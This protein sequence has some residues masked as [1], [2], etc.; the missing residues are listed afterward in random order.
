[1]YK[2]QGLKDFSVLIFPTAL[3]LDK[4]QWR[5]SD[6]II[7]YYHNGSDNGLSTALQLNLHKRTDLHQADLYLQ[8]FYNEM[9]LGINGFIAQGTQ[10]SISDNYIF[11]GYTESRI[12]QP[13]TSDTKYKKTQIYYDRWHNPQ[14][15]KD[16]FIQSIT[17]EE[18]TK[19]IEVR[20]NIKKEE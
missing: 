7:V 4:E 10:V 14:L 18:V 1:M 13:I 19:P 5:V 2:R 9:K 6:A 15:S 3:V 11:Q 17:K 20:F 16:D 8:H 12:M